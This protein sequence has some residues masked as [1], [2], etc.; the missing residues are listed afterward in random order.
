MEEEK[1]A[2]HTNKKL[3]QELEFKLVMGPQDFTREC[4]LHTVAKLI[5]TNDQ[6]SH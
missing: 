5:A 1:E 2:G 6:V 4:V 3:Q